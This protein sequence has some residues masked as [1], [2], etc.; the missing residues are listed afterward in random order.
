MRDV[1]LIDLT[2][3][4]SLVVQLPSWGSPLV[5]TVEGT[6]IWAG[7]NADRKNVVFGFDAFNLEASRFALFIPASPILLSRCLEWLD[8]P[9]TTVQPNVVTVGTPV[10]IFLTEPE[11][12]DDISVRLPDG[13]V[14][15][16]SSESAPIIFT[17][18]SLV[19][20]YTVFVHDRQVGRFAV[21]LLESQD[22]GS[23]PPQPGEER[24]ES[25]P[26]GIP[27]AD[28]LQEVDREIWK[29]TAC[30][31]VLLLLIEWWVYHRNR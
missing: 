4:E 19:G 26:A 17:N 28:H 30:L 15:E 25:D 10:K 5:E 8:V 7:E 20:V 6:L 22:S 11:A 9:H 13:S 18:T 29:Y 16:V 23:S 24:V 2:V 14:T 27:P 21:N 31:G 3:R 12:E 1:P